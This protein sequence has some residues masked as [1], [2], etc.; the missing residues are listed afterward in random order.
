MYRP[1]GSAA[2][3]RRQ[4]SCGSCR[5]LGLGPIPTVSVSHPATDTEA[6]P[7]A[8]ITCHDILVRAYVKSTATAEV[9]PARRCI[10]WHS[11]SV[12]WHVQVHRMGVVE[13]LEEQCGFEHST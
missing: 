12:R 9:R 1:G 6:L 13:G 2:S 3:V 4:V 7:S 11:F 8:K 5:T 10:C